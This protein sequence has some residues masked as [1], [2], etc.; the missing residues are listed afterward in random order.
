MDSSGQKVSLPS[1]ARRQGNGKVVLAKS[2]HTGDVASLENDGS[3]RTSGYIMQGLGK[4]S[5]GKVHAVHED[6][7]LVP[8]AHITMLCAV[9]A[10]VTQQQ[11]NGDRWMDPYASLGSQRHQ[12]NEQVPG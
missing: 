12:L 9:H 11:G 3:H 2:M 10:L 1:L 8:R 7:T 5:A 4:D 6:L